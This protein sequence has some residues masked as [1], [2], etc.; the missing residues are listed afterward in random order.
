MRTLLLLIIFCMGL[1]LQAQQ[2]SAA[3]QHVLTLGTEPQ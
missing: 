1:S 3:L 2:K